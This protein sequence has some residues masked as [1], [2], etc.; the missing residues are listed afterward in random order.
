MN[1]YNFVNWWNNFNFH[2]IL[3][4]LF[5]S[6]IQCNLE[7]DKIMMFGFI[8]QCYLMC[9]IVL[10]RLQSKISYTQ[11]KR[12]Y[13]NKWDNFP[14]DR[15]YKNLFKDQQKD[16]THIPHINYTSF[17]YSLLIHCIGDIHDNWN[18]SHN[19]HGDSMHIQ[20]HCK[21]LRRRANRNYNKY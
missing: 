12:F 15:V 4:T 16:L 1:T 3:N 9:Y 7:F 11:S 5:L 10:I 20:Y 21:D 18:I 13:S 14:L 6:H 17:W 19:L 2:Y 8:A